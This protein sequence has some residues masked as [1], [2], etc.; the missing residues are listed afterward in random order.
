MAAKEDMP[1]TGFCVHEIIAE[2]TSG[3]FRGLITEIDDVHP[4]ARFGLMPS[5][6]CQSIRPVLL[7]RPFIPP[8]RAVVRL[9]ARI[10]CLLRFCLFYC[11]GPW[12]GSRHCSGGGGG[13]PGVLSSPRALAVLCSLS[14]RSAVECGIELLDSA[15]VCK[16]ALFSQLLAF[17]CFV[18][19]YFLAAL[20]ENGWEWHS[21]LRMDFPNCI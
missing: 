12:V 19:Y 1:G 20:F 14:F 5:I 18:F 17:Y 21:V 16:T 4:I 6:E 9:V 2:F 11:G 8:V 7:V 10:F 13:Q 15:V 3:Q